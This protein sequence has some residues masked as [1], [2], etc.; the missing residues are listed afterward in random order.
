[1]ISNIATIDIPTPTPYNHQLNSIPPTITSTY[2]S[3][4]TRD[5]THIHD[6]FAASCFTSSSSPG[7]KRLCH[8]RGNPPTSE[9][10]LSLMDFSFDSPT[11]TPPTLSSEA[12]LTT[13]GITD[14]GCTNIILPLSV[15]LFHDLDVQPFEHLFSIHFPEK[16]TSAIID[17]GVTRSN[18]FVWNFIAITDRTTLVL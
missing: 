4:L 18:N 6:Q 12:K 16:G 9:L 14:T 13:S 1:M 3:F 15:T 10:S 7:P 5:C 11:I 2:W 17:Q 8:S